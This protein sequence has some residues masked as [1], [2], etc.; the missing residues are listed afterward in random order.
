[1]NRSR[2]TTRN[3]AV[4]L[5]ATILCL[6]IARCGNS[7]VGISSA[8]QGASAQVA[9]QTAATVMAEHAAEKA[10]DFESSNENATV[11][12]STGNTS[13]LQAG[14]AEYAA[15]GETSEAKETVRTATPKSQAG[16]EADTQETAK[17]EKTSEHI[18]FDGETDLEY[19]AR[20]ILEADE[21]IAR[22]GALGIAAYLWQMGFGKMN[23]YPAI[24]EVD[25]GK[26]L[27][28]F[29]EEG[30]FYN[31][32]LTPEG[33]IQ[34]VEDVEGNELVA[35][36][37]RAGELIK[38]PVSGS[39]VVALLEDWKE[40]DGHSKVVSAYNQYAHDWG[41]SRMRSDDQWCSE[42]VSAA[43]AALGIADK[44]GGMASNGKTYEQNAR[45]IGAWVS[46]NGYTPSTGDILITHDS[47]GDRHTACVVS[48][49]G[50]KIKTI[51]GGGSGIHHGSISVDS[52][53]IT[54][55]V[56]PEW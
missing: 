8:S 51:A 17:E 18:N 36:G 47:N 26:V 56:V 32:F 24:S 28:V 19:N 55:F 46:G 53:R 29:D 43:Y 42:T 33:K 37:T 52:G 5:S 22:E 16:Q 4:M 9:A 35:L 11:E 6:T 54:G 39:D 44:I 38:P 13:S 48:C 25:G 27:T 45:A 50:S 30:L 15:E 49:D 3:L 10:A 34:S 31:I 21:D 7:P 40:H 14:V 23:S 41:R 2:S 1:M 12:A 20:Q